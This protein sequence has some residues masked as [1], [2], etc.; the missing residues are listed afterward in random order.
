MYL[1]MYSE[2]TQFHNHNI[3]YF[4]R[5]KKS[6]VLSNNVR[7]GQFYELSFFMSKLFGTKGLHVEKNEKVIKFLPLPFDK[8]KN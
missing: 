2:K 6:H 3:G 8:S 1:C 5:R 7:K 4:F